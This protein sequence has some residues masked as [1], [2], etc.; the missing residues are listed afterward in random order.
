MIASM[1]K[2]ASTVPAFS[3][4]STAPTGVAETVLNAMTCRDVRDF[5]EVRASESDARQGCRDSNWIME[6]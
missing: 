6:L 2:L 1:F 4:S 3:V 5:R